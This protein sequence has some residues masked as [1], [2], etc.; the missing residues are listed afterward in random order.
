MADVEKRC[1]EKV[2]QFVGKHKGDFRA[3]V[4]PLMMN[5]DFMEDYIDNYQEE[6]LREKHR[7]FI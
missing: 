6:Y 7:S 5:P 3:D 4:L 1:D 2:V